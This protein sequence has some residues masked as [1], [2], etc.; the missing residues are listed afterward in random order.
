MRNA[1]VR[2]KI[3]PAK[4]GCAEENRKQNK[5]GEEGTQL[6]VSESTFKNL[7]KNLNT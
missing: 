7:L 3:V 4:I 2:E 6:L 1:E 5:S